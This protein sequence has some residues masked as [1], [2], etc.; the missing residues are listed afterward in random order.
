VGPERADG[1]FSKGSHHVAMQKIMEVEKRNELA[2]AQDGGGREGAQTTQN[3][4]NHQWAYQEP[5]AASSVTVRPMRG[6]VTIQRMNSRDVVVP[7]QSFV[8]S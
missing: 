1:A 3:N 5:H 2:N 8:N 4:T 6:F 7:L